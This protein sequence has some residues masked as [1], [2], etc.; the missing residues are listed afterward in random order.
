MLVKPTEMW[1][2]KLKDL[3]QML[4]GLNTKANIEIGNTIEYDV[5]SYQFNK[6]IVKSTE[7]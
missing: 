6:T 7:L 3:K 1:R 2:N 4:Q 5:R